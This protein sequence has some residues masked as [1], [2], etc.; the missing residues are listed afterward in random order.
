VGGVVPLLV[1]P[2]KKGGGGPQT[3]RL[4]PASN[5]AA[6]AR[7]AA[8][9]RTTTRQPTVSRGG[10]PG[11]GSRVPSI[12]GTPTPAGPKPKPLT[13]RIV[14]PGANTIAWLVCEPLAPIPLGGQREVTIGRHEKCDLVLPHKEVSRHH[15]S[16][17]IVGRQITLEDQGSSNGCYVNGKRCASQVVR[18]GDALQIGPYELELRASNDSDTKVRSDDETKRFD[19][20][21][22]SSAGPGASM[23]GKLEDVPLVELLQSI[24]FNK[25]TCTLAISHGKMRGT[26]TF[27]KGRPVSASLGILRDF[28]AARAMLRLTE[29]RFV[30]SLEVEVG[31]PTMSATVTGLLLE[32]SREIDEASTWKSV[33]SPSPS[34]EP[35]P[36]ETVPE[37]APVEN[38]APPAAESAPSVSVSEADPVPTPVE[39]EKAVRPHPGDAPTEM[40]VPVLDDAALE[41]YAKALA[42]QVEPPAEPK[43]ASGDAAPDSPAPPSE[44]AS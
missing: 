25:K 36:E 41:A 22:L 32:A 2:S 1:D 21:N 26:M 39:L 4:N 20:A 10:Q 44:P 7:L 3:T 8:A 28:E 43:V 30:V 18:V 34:E 31:E 17:K 35:A 12:L 24:E 40:S 37:T 5:A 29:G 15:A 16:I 23:T 14:Q 19:M 33:E 42:E 13:S 9:G 27:G 38:E 11:S 6:N